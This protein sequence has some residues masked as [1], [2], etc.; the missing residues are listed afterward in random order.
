LDFFA[1]EYDGYTENYWMCDC[2]K[3]GNRGDIR[4]SWFELWCE[5]CGLKREEGHA[6]SMDQVV[7][8]LKRRGKDVE[9]G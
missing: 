6:V 7:E 4:C 2:G 9:R 5:G 8:G 3:D 1:D